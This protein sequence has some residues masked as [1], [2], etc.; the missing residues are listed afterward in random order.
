[1][2]LVSWILYHVSRLLSHASCLIS[3]VSCF[4]SPVSHITSHISCCKSP[5]SLLLSHISCLPS[6]VARLLSHVSCH[7]SQVSC[8]VC[9]VSFSTLTTQ[10]IVGAACRVSKGD[11]KS[12]R[13][14]SW[15][16]LIFPSVLKI[17]KLLKFLF[18]KE[19]MSEERRE[20]FALW[21]KKGGNCQ[22]YNSFFARDSLESRA[23]HSHCSFLKSNQSC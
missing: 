2:S 19:W 9:C 17:P 10:W 4:L 8:I 14:K 5:V 3:P 16:V 11:A 6:P 15:M 12:N 22:K 20:R 13:F 21:H 23:N 7:M 18:K 1:M